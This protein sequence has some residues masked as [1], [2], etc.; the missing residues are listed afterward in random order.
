MKKLSV[1]EAYGDK[2]IDLGKKYDNLVVL[3]A[4]IG[5][6]SKSIKF[7]KEFPDRYFNVGIA[8]LDMV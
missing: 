7:G 5:N 1:R 2:L 8:E 6:S 3:E 4:D